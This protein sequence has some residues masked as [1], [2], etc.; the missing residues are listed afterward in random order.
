MKSGKEEKVYKW[1]EFKYWVSKELKEISEIV[2]EVDN[3]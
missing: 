3:I 2:T 1:K